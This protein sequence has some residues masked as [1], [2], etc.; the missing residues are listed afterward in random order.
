MYSATF[1][2]AKRAAAGGAAFDLRACRGG[3]RPAAL[4]QPAEGPEQAGDAGGRAGERACLF[5]AHQRRDARSRVRPRSRRRAP[6]ASP[7]GC[8]PGGRSRRVARRSSRRPSRARR[9][10]RPGVGRGRWRRGLRAGGV[11][12]PGCSRCWSCRSRRAA[13]RRPRRRS[14][15]QQR[16]EAERPSALQ[17]LAG[18][19][20]DAEGR[21]PCGIHAA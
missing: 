18:E 3:E 17:V 12:R 21:A 16:R 9:R 5:L 13:R 6:S 10:S 8:S 19:P 4:G 2:R 15:E 1:S 11:P 20:A 14:S 7:V